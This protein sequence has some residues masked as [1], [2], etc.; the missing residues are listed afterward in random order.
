MSDMS[1]GTLIRVTAVPGTENS[2]RYSKKDCSWFGILSHSPGKMARKHFC[3][4]DVSSNAT[5]CRMRISF[6]VV[7]LSRG[8]DSLQVKKGIQNHVHFSGEK[9]VHATQEMSQFEKGT[10]KDLQAIM[11][12]LMRYITD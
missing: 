7:M 9:E 3:Q 12:S 10:K 5:F 1:F 8:C 4:Y 6:P 2:P 11:F